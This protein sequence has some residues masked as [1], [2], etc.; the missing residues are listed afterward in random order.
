M[1]ARNMPKMMTGLNVLLAV[2]MLTHSVESS[3]IDLDTR[4]KYWADRGECTRSVEFMRHNCEL[5]CRHCPEA[6]LEDLLIDADMQTKYITGMLVTVLTA[7]ALAWVKVYFA[8][9]SCKSLAKLK[10]KTVIVTGANTGI[11]L[12]TALSFAGRGAKVIIA[13]KN[14]KSGLKALKYI[15]DLSENRFVEFRKVDLSSFDSIREFAKEFNAE[16]ERLD[17]LVNNAGVLTAAKRQ[18]TKDGHEEMFQV[19]HLGPFLLTNLL[20]EKMKKSSPSRIVNVSCGIHKKSK[21][22]NFTDLEMKEKFGRFKQFAQ[23]KLANLLFTHELSKELEGTNITANSVNPGYVLSDAYRNVG[24]LH[25]K[26]AK[27]I[28]YPFMFVFWKSTRQGA[29]TSIRVAVDPALEKVT[30]KYF[31]DCLECDVSPFGKDDGA[32]KK[33]WEISERLTGLKK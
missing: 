12:D 11:G 15:R 3:C 13:C 33:L 1:A 24:I 14:Y 29:Q 4:C 17:I 7:I 32:A 9:G 23:T 21:G 19:N 2:A 6:V 28:L 5:S 8:G 18:V 30:G 25:W 27:L 20:L 31:E 22:L 10:G 16:E 26:I